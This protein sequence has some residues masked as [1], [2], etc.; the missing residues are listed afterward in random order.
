MFGSYAKA[1]TQLGEPRMRGIVLR[2]LAATLILYV[3]LYALVAW[4][5]GQVH[6]FG[7]HWLDSLADILGGVT[8]FI[9]TLL[10]FPAVASTVLSFL[11]E[12]VARAVEARHYPGLPEP[13]RQSLAE[14]GWGALRFALVT[15]VVNL[16]A[17]PF[18]LLLLLFGVGIGL[19]Y[20]VN[21]YLLAREYFELVAWRRL[22]PARADALRRAH[23]GRLWLGGIGL[24]VLSTLPFVN[25]VAPLIGTAAMVHEFEALR[26]RD[27]I[28]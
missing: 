5:L 17:L 9:L 8:V 18:Y 20:I 22:D 12:S 1:I 2:G 3:L 24:A 23:G 19:Y 27:N 21:G 11:L 28:V 26:R 7:I 13:R 25:L 4:G 16:I 15:L 14:I 10:L 6:L